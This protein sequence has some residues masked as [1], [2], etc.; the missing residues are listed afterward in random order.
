MVTYTLDFSQSVTGK[1]SEYLCCKYDNTAKQNR[2]PCSLRIPQSSQLNAQ[3]NKTRIM[4]K[5]VTYN[6]IIRY[7]KI[8]RLLLTEVSK[9]RLLLEPIT[10]RTSNYFI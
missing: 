8:M 3:V 6:R 7:N 1:T 4:T 5:K 2:I 10:L 9:F